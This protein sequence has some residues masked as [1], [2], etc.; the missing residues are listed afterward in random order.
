MF[1]WL[2]KKGIQ[3][4]AQDIKNSIYYIEIECDKNS[5]EKVCNQLAKLL[6]IG[7]VKITDER[8]PIAE[9]ISSFMDIKNKIIKE[10]K[11][12]DHR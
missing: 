12:K 5:A 10:N 1:G 7:L 8:V 3:L 2:A 4:K 9:I 6:I 11:L